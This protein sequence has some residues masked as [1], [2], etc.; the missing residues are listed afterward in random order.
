MPFL[1][2][3]TFLLAFY[4]FAHILVLNFFYGSSEGLSIYWQE[5]FNVKAIVV[6]ILSVLVTV[7]FYVY[8]T[9][10]RSSLLGKVKVKQ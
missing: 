8:V 6:Y 4:L 3:K 5:N 9:K 2:N 7:I 10:I 1:K